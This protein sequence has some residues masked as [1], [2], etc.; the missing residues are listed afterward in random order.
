MGFISAIK[1]ANNSWANVTADFFEGIGYLG[2]KNLVD[3]R[4]REMMISAPSLKDAYVFTKSDVKSIDTI[5]ATSEWIK[6]KICFNDG[7]TA[8]ATFMA[9]DTTQQGRKPANNLLNFEF[10]MADVIYRN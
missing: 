5:C 9:I 3:N 1:G 6:F 2:P 4:S 7:K 10:W 8:I